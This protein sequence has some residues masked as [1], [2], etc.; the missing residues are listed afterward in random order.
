[1]KWW[2]DC[3]L[4]TADVHHRSTLIFLQFSKFWNCGGSICTLRGTVLMALPCHAKKR[5]EDQAEFFS[6]MQ[7]V[8]RKAIAALQCDYSARERERQTEPGEREEGEKAPH[9]L[10][11]HTKEE[12]EEE[13]EG[14]GIKLTNLRLRD[15][16]FNVHG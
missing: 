15:G 13:E 16:R 12:E 8:G 6:K 3:R 1:M 9:N 2:S 10:I 7:L 5:E 11:T 14:R 4:Q